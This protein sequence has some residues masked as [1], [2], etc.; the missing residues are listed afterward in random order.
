ME[1]SEIPKDLQV[2]MTKDTGETFNNLQLYLIKNTE[3]QFGSLHEKLLKYVSADRREKILKYHFDV[4]KVLSLY[5]AVLTR[6]CLIHLL[7]CKNNELHFLYEENGKPYLD[8]DKCGHLLG[9][10]SID[11]NFSHTKNAVFLGVIKNGSIGTDIERIKAAP[12][13]VMDSV[14]HLEEKKY[15]LEETGDK[16]NERFFEIWTRKEAFSKCSGLGL[17]SDLRSV[18]T[19]DGPY[20]KYIFTKI[21]DGYALSVCYSP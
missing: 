3:E 8:P 2:Y 7:N 4:D 9:S 5:G 21:L 16:R 10:D 13:K 11:F 14:F 6:Y 17:L 18:N 15:V 20:L 19:L 12:L 1:H